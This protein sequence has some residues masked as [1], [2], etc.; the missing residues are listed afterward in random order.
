M[1]PR[2]CP[3]KSMKKGIDHIGNTVVFFCHDGRGRFVMGKR[4]QNARDEKGR[5]DIGGGGIELHDTV[6]NTLKKEIMEE[7][8]TEV[9][10]FEL[11]G[12]RDVHRVH[13]SEATHWIALDFKVLVNPDQVKIGEPHKLDALEWFTLDDMP[14]MEE[15]HSQWPEFL[16]LYKHR[17]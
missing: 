17:L 5:W 1:I 12:Y 7:Y 8:C 16:K 3:W 15:S 2:A 13:N 9:L 14:V 6:E 10:G 4:S 11:L